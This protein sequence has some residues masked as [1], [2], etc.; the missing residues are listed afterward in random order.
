M[1]SNSKGVMVELHSLKPFTYLH[2]TIK[3]ISNDYAQEVRI[4]LEN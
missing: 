2:E 4:Y 1:K 3:Y